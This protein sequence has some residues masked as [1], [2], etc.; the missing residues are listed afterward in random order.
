MSFADDLPMVV[1]SF[2]ISTAVCW[3]LKLIISF[4]DIQY[5]YRFEDYRSKDYESKDY[6]SEDYRSKDYRSKDYRFI[7]ITLKRFQS[8]IFS[9]N[10]NS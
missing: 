4:T 6:G 9:R 8:T 3:F 5:D 1:T 2:V 10:L 7:I